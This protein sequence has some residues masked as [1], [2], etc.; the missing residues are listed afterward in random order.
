MMWDELPQDLPRLALPLYEGELVG[1]PRDVRDSSN[2][3]LV[4]GAR[5][6]HP[7]RHGV[8]G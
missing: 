7:E 4:T 1:N 5:V 2:T 8:K 6:V 3:G